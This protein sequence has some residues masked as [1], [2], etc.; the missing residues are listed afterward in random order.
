MGLNLNDATGKQRTGITITCESCIVIVAYSPLYF[1]S[2]DNIHNSVHKKV[3]LMA[4]R[5]FATL[6]TELLCIQGGGNT[7][8][9]LLAIY[10]IY[11]L[12][13]LSLR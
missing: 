9:K 12:I 2:S 4:I 11:S 7:V 8:S 5:L 6:S 3:R 10:L 1:V 13:D